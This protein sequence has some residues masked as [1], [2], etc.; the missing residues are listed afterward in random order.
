MT[1][2]DRLRSLAD[3]ATRLYPDD[4]AEYQ[5]ARVCRETLRFIAPDL[6]RWAANAYDALDLTHESYDETTE[7]FHE[8]HSEPD[9]KAEDCVVCRIGALLARLDEIAGDGE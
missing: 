2:A 7:A 4:G 5:D 6:A 8:Q 1:A 9:G 3:K